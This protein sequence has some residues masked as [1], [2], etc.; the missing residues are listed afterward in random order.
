VRRL[1][2]AD[3]DEV[4]AFDAPI[5][6]AG[7]AAV[8]RSSCERYPGRAFVVEDATGRVSGY[9]IAGR[10][11]IGPWSAA[12]ERAA[13]TLLQAALALAYDDGPRLVLPAS[14]GAGRALLERYG[15]VQTETLTHMR[16]GG[17]ADPR[18]CAH[19][20][21]QASLMLG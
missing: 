11:A 5:F 2:A 10:T 13:E 12:S 6:G 21:A 4:V 3:L 15:F 17:P 8:I 20:Y 19:I 7:R 1:E 14:N 18:D 16:R 9:L